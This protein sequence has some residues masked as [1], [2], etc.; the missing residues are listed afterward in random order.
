M[1]ASTSRAYAICSSCVMDTTDSRIVFDDRGICDHCNNYFRHTLRNW[2]THDRG[3]LALMDL[4]D[5]IKR[6]GRGRD[7]DCIIG[8]SGG[9]DS[10]YLTYI[11][12]EQLGLRPLVFHVDTGWNSQEAVNNIEKLV[13]G[14]GL[15]LYTG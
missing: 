7:Y 4:V 6:T 12:T 3:Q 5:K 14:L 11:A 13:E 9:I 2:P 15:D 10:S 8:M 1:S